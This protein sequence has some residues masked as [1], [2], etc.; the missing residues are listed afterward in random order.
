MDEHRVSPS[1]S[2]S[3]TGKAK[4]TSDDSFRDTAG[5]AIS[6]NSPVCTVPSFFYNR[7]VQLKHTCNY[8]LTRVL[9]QTHT[10]RDC[11]LSD[12]SLFVLSFPQFSLLLG[13][14]YCGLFDTCWSNQFLVFCSIAVSHYSNRNKSVAMESDV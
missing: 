14:L 5:S 2:P 7:P 12:K 10:Q 9:I 8:V 13:S 3:S 11:S 4:C 6:G 1:D